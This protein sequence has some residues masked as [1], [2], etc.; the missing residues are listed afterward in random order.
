M[1]TSLKKQRN[2]FQNSNKINMTKI[3]KE[4]TLL[5]SGVKTHSECKS[6]KK[7]YK[8]SCLKSDV[9]SKVR[10]FYTNDWYIKTI[11][12]I[13][14]ITSMKTLKEIKEKLHMFKILLNINETLETDTELTIE[15]LV[16]KCI[17]KRID[18]KHYCTTNP[19]EKHDAEILRHVFYHERLKELKT[20]FIHVKKRYIY[21]KEK[22]MET[23][24]LEDEARRLEDE[25]RRLEDLEELAYIRLSGSDT[26]DTFIPVVSKK[27]KRKS[28]PK[29]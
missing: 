20:L 24:R 13:N 26:S 12:E 22:Q 6:I 4:Y 16:K 27:T 1:Q 28:R 10:E 9:L 14:T 7:E 25:A 8:Q 11:H 15:K 29:I 2:Q 5:D 23:R 3:S 19:D 17:K 18:Y 21:V